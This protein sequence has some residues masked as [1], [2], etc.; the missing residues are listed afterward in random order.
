MLGSIIW[1]L[2]KFNSGEKI[3]KIS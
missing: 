2:F 1:V 3:L